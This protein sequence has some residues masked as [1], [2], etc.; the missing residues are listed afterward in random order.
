MS[1]TPY[2]TKHLYN[3]SSLSFTQLISRKELKQIH[4]IRSTLEKETSDAI[5]SLHTKLRGNKLRYENNINYTLCKSSPGLMGYGRYVGSRGSLETLERSV[6]GS[7]CHQYYYD[8]DV[9][10]CHP[11]IIPQMAKRNYNFDMPYLTK[12]VANRSH[13]FKIMKDKYNYD[14]DETKEIVIRILYNG[15]C[16]TDVKLSADW[17]EKMIEDFHQIK[18]EMVTFTNYLIK[19]S[20]HTSLLNFLKNSKKANL[21]GSITSWIVQTEERKIL[22]SMVQSLTQQGFFVDVLAYDGC[23]VRKNNDNIPSK[24]IIDTVE[25][26]IKKETSY[27][28]KLKIKSFTTLS[29]DEEKSDDVTAS[30]L[31][32]EDVLIDD[33]Y[34]CQIFINTMG[35]DMIKK[36]GIIW[37]YNSSNGLWETGDNGV[38]RAVHSNYDSLV[39]KQK[40][41]DGNIKIF[42]YGGSTKNI[43]Q[44]LHNLDALLSVTVSEFCLQKSKGSLLFTNGY[45]DMKEKIFHPGFDATCRN[46]FFTKRIIRDYKEKQLKYNDVLLDDV[47]KILFE[48]PYNNNDIGKY[49]KYVISR[50]IAGHIEDKTW[51][52]IVGNPDCGK[53]VISSALKNTF[54][55]YVGLYNPNVLKFN[56][57]DGTDEPRK[58]AWYVPLIGSRIALGNEVRLDGK[59]L[60]GNQMKTLSSGGDL[61]QLRENFTN[62]STID[63]VTTFFILV[64]D[65]PP[66]TPCDQALKNRLRCIPHTKSFV[67]KAQEDCNEYESKGDPLLKDKLMTSDWIN[68]FFW[69]IMDAYHE[70][71]ESPQEVLDESDELFIVEDI[72]LKTIL[73]ERYEFVGGKE[74]YIPSREII[75]YLQDEGVKLS[76]T[77]IGRELRKIGLVSDIKKIDKKVCRVYFGLKE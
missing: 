68:A 22:E 4:S 56:S 54:D 19:D 57:R 9:V 8:I 38:L 45:Y 30:D 2:S 5:H 47:N 37:T 31:V 25:Q 39:L 61:I 28:I 43:K 66:I 53:G 63:M 23:Q 41:K 44:M 51:V 12:Y 42:N 27:G 3:L 55:E 11:T 60:D 1:D 14:E 17:S 52:S 36:D 58:L 75:K 59:S 29:L 48:N 6:R 21:N 74:S 50:A 62:Q 15:A 76:D 18:K 72:K 10:N 65:M 73:E 20:A 69:I 33:K 7:L 13:Y 64:N 71:I 26:I 40:D 49:Y 77:K 34:A 67:N 32:P 70:P 46:K 16:P 24:E 35:D